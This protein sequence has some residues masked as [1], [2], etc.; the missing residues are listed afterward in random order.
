[1]FFRICNIGKICKYI[2]V[3]NCKTLVNA[4]VTSQLHYCNALYNVM[5]C[6]TLHYIANKKCKL[7]YPQLF[8]IPINSL[9]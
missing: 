6:Q 2:D 5:V 4:L 7:I 8:P 3:E 1:M 9:A